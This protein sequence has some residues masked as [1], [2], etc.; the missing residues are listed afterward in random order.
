M[1][2]AGKVQMALLSVGYSTFLY[3][4][5][6]PDGFPGRAHIGDNG[7]VF[8]IHLMFFSLSFSLSSIIKKNVQCVLLLLLNIHI[9]VPQ[10]CKK[11]LREIKIYQENILR[12]LEKNCI[13]N[14]SSIILFYWS[15][16]RNR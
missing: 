8:L 9:S 4:R 3:A 13:L 10:V 11:P 2:L 12:F 7:K 5:R 14:Y 1:V 15:L 16:T 6:W